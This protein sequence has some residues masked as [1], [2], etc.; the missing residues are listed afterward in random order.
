[1]WLQ[2]CLCWCSGVVDLHLSTCLFV[3]STGFR[4]INLPWKRV[5]IELYCITSCF[6]DLTQTTLK[7]CQMMMLSTHTHIHT[8]TKT[9][10]HTHTY[11]RACA[12]T[13]AQ[14]TARRFCCNRGVWPWTIDTYLL[15]FILYGLY[16]W[17]V[18]CSC[19]QWLNIRQ[20]CGFKEENMKRDLYVCMCL[21]VCMVKFRIMLFHWQIDYMMFD[22][23]CRSLLMCV[24][25]CMYVW[26]SL[27]WFS[28]G[29]SIECWVRMRMSPCCVVVFS[30]WLSCC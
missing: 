27:N 21:C 13:H 9:H 19:Y 26:K 7:P 1:M 17:S 3:C 22:L 11:A 25:V 29:E 16:L 24:C 15:F 30:M 6:G 12:Y 10:T 28:E 18:G 4:I 14:K 23:L 5:W 20:Y 2:C 8:L